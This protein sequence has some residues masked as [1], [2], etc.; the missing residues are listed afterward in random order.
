MILTEK[1]TGSVILTHVK[2]D[3]EKPETLRQ[4]DL[5]IGLRTDM[6]D[7]KLKVERDLRQAFDQALEKHDQG[8]LQRVFFCGIRIP[9]FTAEKLS[10]TAVRSSM[11]IIPC[12]CE[13]VS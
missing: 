7:S 4:R 13:L 6:L 5:E 2:R 12:T 11:H 1:L 8:A 3:L 9:A 10:H